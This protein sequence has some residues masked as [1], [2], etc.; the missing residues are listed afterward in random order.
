MPYWDMSESL[1]INVDQVRDIE[2]EMDI[3]LPLSL[4][5]AAKVLTVNKIDSGQVIL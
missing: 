4:R 3:R 2:R 1:S 5:P